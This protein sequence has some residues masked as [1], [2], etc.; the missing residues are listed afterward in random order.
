MEQHRSGNAFS[1]IVSIVVQVAML[2]TMFPISRHAVAADTVQTLVTSFQPTINE[3]IDASG[4]KHPGVGFTKDMLENMRTQVQAQK[5]PWNTYFNQML[6]SSS[7]SKTAGI[8][9]INSSNSSLPRYTAFNSQGVETAFKA[10]AQTAYTQA[11]LYYVTGDETYRSNALHIIRL[12]EQMD[13]AQYAYYTDAAIHTGIALQRMTGAA[14]ILRYTNYQTASLAWTDNDTTTFTNNLVIP[15]I[16]TFD[17]CNCRFMNQHLYTTIAAMSGA[18]FMGSQD[19]YAKAVEWF[20]V[21]KDAVDQGQNGAIKRLFRLVETNDLTGEA[22]TP[23]VQHVEMGRDQAHGGGDITNAEILARLMMAQGTKVDPVD[24]T[25]STAPDAVGPYEFLNDRILDAAELYA[26]YMTGHEIPWIPTASHMDANGV[27][28]V[29]YKNVAWGYRGR[30]G[31]NYW[32]LF[33]YYQYTR[34]V[35]MTQRAPNFTKYFADRIGYAWDSGDGGGDFW[36]GIPKSAE[37]EG[38]KYLVKLP[39]DPYREV[40]DRYTLLDNNSV[41]MSDD[42]GTFIRSTATPEGTKY[43]VFGYGYGATSY[44]IRIRTNGT[45]ILDNYGTSIPLPNTHGEWRYVIFSGNVNDYIPLTIT[46][47][48]TTVDVDK[49]NVQASTLLTPPAFTM[50]T[51]DV[52][53]YTY[54]GATQATTLDLS[55]TD[56]GVGETVTYQADN[57]PAGASF[58]T[59][60]G[61]FFWN[62]TQA[63]TYTFYVSA[64]DGTTVT[65]KTVTIVVDADRQSAVNTADA[66]YKPGTEYVASTLPAYNAAY[67]DMM[68][69]IGTA[70]D[71]VFFQ[72]LAAL[73]TAAAGL[74]EMNPLL[75]DGSLDFTHMFFKSD[76]ASQT[77]IDNLVDNNQDTGGGWGPNLTFNMDF[78][79]SFK[80]AANDFKIRADNGFPERVGGVAM[81]GSNDNE[82]WTRLT[83]GLTA[84]VDPMQDMPV[85]DTL[86]NTK[87]RFLKMQMI[88]PWLPSYQPSYILEFTEFRIFGTRTPTVNKLS[89]VSL[90]SDQALKNRLIPGN[91]VKL[92][93]VSTEAITNVS[94]TIQGQPAT[95]TTTDNLNWTATAVVNSTT[96]AGNVKFLLNYKT[97]AG[98]DA[99]PTLFTTDGSSLWV[100]DQ[101][102]YISNLLDITTRTDSSGRNATD[103]QTVVNYLFDS[104]VTTGTDF[105]VNSSGWGAWLEFDFRGGGTANLSRVEIL[106]RQDSFYYRINGT[107]IQG[108]NDNSTW[109]TISNAAGS[110]ADWQI[111]KINDTT[112]YRYIRV[113]NGG[114]W[115]GNMNELRFFGKTAST[116]KIASA[117][118]SSPQAMRNRIVPGNTAKVTFTA[119]EAISNVTATIQGQQATV[120]TTD[121]INFT[122]TAT[123][124][125]G[126]AAGAVNFAIN[127]TTQ[128][129]KVG[130]PASA[131]TDTTSLNLVDEADT[132]KNVTSIATLIDSTSGRTAASTLTITNYL[133]DGNIS[134]GSDYRLGTSGTGG[135]ITFDFKSGNQA[136]LT[137]VE[138]LARQDQY[139][140]RAKYT[141]IQGSNDNTNWT[142]LTTGAAATLEWQTLPVTSRVPY[143]YIRIW[144]AT[145]WY[146]N[147]NEVRFH[148]TVNLADS[149]APV[150]TA[151]APQGTVGTNATVTFTATDNSGGSG[152]Q[153]TYYTVDGGAQQT[154]TSV[155]LT[156]DGT[157]TVAYWSVDWAGNT[158]QQK[159]V[160]VT[161]DKT[162]PALAG[163]YADITVPTNQNVA[164]TIYYP[165][166]AVVRDYKVGDSGAWTPYTAPVVMSDN[167]IVYARSA[168]AVGNV[169]GIASYTV[170]NIY[171]VPPSG[172]VLTADVTDPTNGNVTLTIVYPT[173]NVVLTQYKVGDS[174]TWTAYTGP[175]VVTD[176]V[177][178]YAQSIDIA[179]N[180]SS[181]TSY[182]VGNIDRVPPADAALSADITV[183][184]NKDVTVTIAYPSD[185][186]V[187]E[188]KVGDSGT[189][190]P[191]GGPVVVSSN[192]TVYARSADAAGNAS[193]VT[194]Y[195]VDYIDR[196]PPV[197]AALAVDTSAPTNQGVTVTIAYPDDAAVKE[198]KVGDTGDWTP[199]TA[200]VVVQDDNVVYAR[201]TDAV[202]NVSIVTSI[203]VSNIYKV[204]PVTIAT[205]SPAAPNGKNSWYTTDVSVNLAVVP[206]AYGGAVTT[207]YQVNDGAWIPYTGSVAFGEGVYTLGYRSRDEAGNVEQVKTI[208]FNVDKTTPVLSVQLDKSTI[209]PPNHQMVPVNAT[210]SSNDAVSGMD[211]VVLSSITSNKPDGGQGD[212]Q[213]SFGTGA[214]TFSVRAEKDRIYTITYTATDKAGNKTVKTSTVTVPHDESGLQ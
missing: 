21:N 146:G 167:G 177:T 181:V 92:S 83:P 15:V 151:T 110:S 77:M 99:E 11:I 46:G 85:D 143:R 104:N 140:T 159:T 199:Y 18:I 35:D 73:R 52:T 208:T 84:R 16:D 94:A 96:P 64:S 144:N 91:T 168:D 174:G 108:S 1:K 191:Y 160:T 122:A 17:S 214:T 119:K 27:P 30:S 197:A 102:D 165:L 78:G 76:F 43:S 149:T 193:N 7:A 183:A 80:I 124:P 34:G 54:A 145:A 152:I 194:Q 93:F 148:G 171:K 109:T 138:L 9:N 24:G 19:R 105:R 44:G 180:V 212:I 120:S 166:D 45:A 156:T 42:T 139:Y 157:H 113:Y 175:V 2:A 126:V 206:G 55:A 204:V 59:S 141:V 127:Y 28:F 88:Q 103:L 22:V 201:G 89:S 209:W 58:N 98:V 12:Y 203:V 61:A 163:L 14:E 187:Q 8:V 33:Y 111:L 153:A 198:Y 150:T 154:G 161:I 184:T 66:R 67:N 41:V 135:Y 123:L 38:G 129:G 137:G 106:P 97:A 4:F 117:S 182:V 25:I 31:L 170:G 95:I 86:K 50:G 196:T 72:K 213:A 26:T 32:E 36:I 81:F 179:G 69:V 56:P 164:V 107:V 10:D 125:Q 40:E 188:Y 82:N 210:L 51:A 74:Q 178:V 100:S 118:I 37:A 57:L 207:E 158:E 176:N 133:F 195:V 79:P 70:T 172:A 147:L 136:T 13:P 205:L 68:S 23:A 39:V 128:D 173:T 189:W 3:T 134:T 114:Q 29:V 112:P 49:L 5:E 90:S 185:A 60:T 62:P 192:T 202:G 155:T 48:G 63:G 186:A 20:T 130:Y 131:V 115:F 53:L 211:S 169:S 116:A 142:T 87:F 6:L 190:A 132:I 200:P 101:T 71:D 75:S 65:M 121:N 162:A 47:N